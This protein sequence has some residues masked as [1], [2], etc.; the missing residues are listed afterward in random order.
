MAKQKK[1]T[2]KPLPVKAVRHA[3]IEL[4][5]GDYDRLRSVAKAQGLAV[6]AYIRR[7]VLMAVRKDEAD[8][9]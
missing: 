3:R 7:A 4:S 5:A 6:A 1:P 8:G 9:V 2:G